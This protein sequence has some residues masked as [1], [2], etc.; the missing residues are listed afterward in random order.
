MKSIGIHAAMPKEYGAFNRLNSIISGQGDSGYTPWEN[1]EMLK[2][3]P[4]AMPMPDFKNP[5]SQRHIWN[6]KF[7]PRTLMEI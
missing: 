4:I 5:N 6:D 3:K 2:N 1:P 7:M